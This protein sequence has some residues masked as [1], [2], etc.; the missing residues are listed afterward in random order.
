[1]LTVTKRPE[2]I[3]LSNNCFDAAVTAD[4]MGHAL[5]TLIGHGLVDN[6]YIY[7][8]SDIEDYNGLWQ[9]DSIT[10]S[11][12][13]IKRGVDFQPYVKP[14][15]IS[16]CKAQT[17]TSWNAVHLPV[18]YEIKSD[19]YP[20]NP[21]D[22]VYF[23]PAP[24]SAG[25]FLNFSL[26]DSS[27]II[28][29]DYVWFKET[30]LDPGGSYQVI[31][32]ES[33]GGGNSKVTINKSQS[34][35]YS[36]Q[37][38]YNNYHAVVKINAGI[39][40]TNPQE[41]IKPYEVLATLKLI[42][43]NENKII[44]SIHEVLKA[45][46]KT[47]NNLLLSSLPN[48]TDFWTSFYISYAESYD[49]SNGESVSTY[50]SSYTDDSFVG[51]VSNSKLPF[52]NKFSGAMSEYVSN[53]DNPG[54]WLTNFQELRVFSDY[55]RDISFINTYDQDIHILYDG[56]VA[57]TI[58]DPGIGVLRVPIDT[59]SAKC[60]TAAISDGTGYGYLAITEPI[61]LVMDLTT[62]ACPS[63]SPE[64]TYSYR[65][66]EDEFLRITEDG[67]YRVIE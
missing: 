8:D 63:P 35:L 37:K 36:V 66:T 24:Y 40:A 28:L 67:A 48:N 42:P 56:V 16:L 6:D 39:P 22:T 11:T 23:I 21:F 1:M 61:C 55:Y 59:S 29:F 17:T 47:R 44:F 34:D 52:K 4:T 26:P 14:F 43:D 53:V 62:T 15:P 2:S 38:Y 13:K 31:G 18:V 27:G 65:I 45:H 32:I 50:L 12:F 54:K 25:D 9:V 33:I 3:I 20:I 58:T 57:F 49:S 51:Y 10:S 19:V 5:V 64:P 41:Y 46:I 7:V 30:A 60:I